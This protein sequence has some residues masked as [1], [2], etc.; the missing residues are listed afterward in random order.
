MAQQFQDSQLQLDLLHRQLA[1]EPADSRG[2]DPDL[3][4][5]AI[6]VPGTKAQDFPGLGEATQELLAD[7]HAPDAVLAQPEA[8]RPAPE[9]PDPAFHFPDEAD[10]F[11]NPSD[12]DSREAEEG[13]DDGF[14]VVSNSRKN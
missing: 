7:C 9:E 11:E 10:S 2:L 5:S 14:T 3:F 12:K 1:R 4:S 6:L 8:L 13:L